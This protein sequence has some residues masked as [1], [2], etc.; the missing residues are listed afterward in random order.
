MKRWAVAA[1]CW[2]RGCLRH[3]AELLLTTARHCS[4]DG[5]KLGAAVAH[6]CCRWSPNRGQTAV[7]GMAGG[8]C[9]SGSACLAT[10]VMAFETLRWQRWWFACWLADRFFRLVLDQRAT[11][12]AAR[13]RRIAGLRI[14]SKTSAT[15]DRMK[16]PRDRP[17]V[18]ARLPYAIA[19][20][21]RIAGRSSQQLAARPPR[22]SRVCL[23]AG[24]H[25]P[26]S[27]Q[28]FAA[29]LGGRFELAYLGITARRA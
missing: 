12:E 2:G 19:S 5:A 29:R 9:L 20:G 13:C 14:L 15:G 24:S 25:S 7:Y 26:W 23:D 28:R 27:V 17:D 21:S 4:V 16:A 18:R 10:I 6:S 1:L 22:A 8:V 11:K 3:S